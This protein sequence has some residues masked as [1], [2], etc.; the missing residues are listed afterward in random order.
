MEED[1]LD[2]SDK[3]NIDPCDNIPAKHKKPASQTSFPKL[4][5]A[6][7][8][9]P[10]IEK[11]QSLN[12]PQQQKPEILVQETD[13]E[14][15]FDEEEIWKSMGSNKA[16]FAIEN[17]NLILRTTGGDFP[18]SYKY[19]FYNLYWPDTDFNSKMVPHLSPCKR[20]KWWRKT[21]PG[22]PTDEIWYPG[23]K[24]C[25]YKD[26]MDMR[27]EVAKV[28][29][30]IHKEMIYAQLTRVQTIIHLHGLTDTELKALG[31]H[32][33]QLPAMPVILEPIF[34]VCAV[35][36]NWYPLKTYDADRDPFIHGFQKKYPAG[37]INIIFRHDPEPPAGR[38]TYN[39]GEC[40]RQAELMKKFT[41][42]NE[43]NFLGRIFDP[44]IPSI[45][46]TPFPFISM[47]PRGPWEMI[48]KDID[49]TSYRFSKAME[50][51]QKQEGNGNR[52]VNL[53]DYMRLTKKAANLRL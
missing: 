9:S 10:A 12:K 36:G 29:I 39:A 26:Y 11:H 49:S 20:N 45:I 23:W 40:L 34:K 8:Y 6:N 30:D 4:P 43:P 17:D 13:V 25:W 35:T 47:G 15:L 28:Y 1:W 33:H 51:A 21:S 41:R 7:V 5:G 24:P 42:Y 27:H 44:D 19:G 38:N 2:D 32:R 31:K 46:Y 48:P 18:R 37:V 50:R 22:Y 3:E 52:T 53:Y 16:E 14:H